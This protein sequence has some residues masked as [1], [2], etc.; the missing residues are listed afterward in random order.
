MSTLPIVYI[1]TILALLH[2][3]FF[4]ICYGK[5]ESPLMPD[6][7]EIML[8]I[9]KSIMEFVNLDHSAF[10]VLGIILIIGDI[11]WIIFMIMKNIGS[12]IAV[13]IKM[14]LFLVIA[15]ALMHFAFIIFEND[16]HLILKLIKKLFSL[17]TNEMDL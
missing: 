5:I 16:S 11:L 4:M 10:K 9:R 13:S 3:N 17:F 15:T 12:F 7:P 14:T 1:I 8:D 2:A 6:L